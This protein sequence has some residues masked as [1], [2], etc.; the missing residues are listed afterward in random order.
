MFI[1]ISW[2]PC[3]PF[4]EWRSIK[5]KY[6]FYF[7]NTLTSQH[8]CHKNPVC[9][10]FLNSCFMSL[11][12]LAILLYQIFNTKF[13]TQYQTNLPLHI[14]NLVLL[15][16]RI[17]IPIHGKIRIASCTELPFFHTFIF[18]MVTIPH[19]K[20]PIKYSF[21]LTF[22]LKHK[23]II[24]PNV[25]LFYTYCIIIFNKTIYL[26]IY[27]KLIYGIIIPSYMQAMQDICLLK[28]SFSFS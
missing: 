22:F 5:E 19:N 6:C 13:S 24:C 1:G 2:K 23:R 9:M 26:F 28:I 25:N 11:D 4:E 15:K 10:D 3:L 27:D 21:D 12:A 8:K 17:N 7:K 16:Y 20:F 14:M 18:Q